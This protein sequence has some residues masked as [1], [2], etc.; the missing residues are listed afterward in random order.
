MDQNQNQQRS[1]KT[2]EPEISEEEH[3]GLVDLDDNDEVDSLLEYNK[4]QQR[5]I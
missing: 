2:K 3:Q 1:T 5:E 4:W